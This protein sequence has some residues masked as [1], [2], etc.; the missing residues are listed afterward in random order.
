MKEPRLWIFIMLVVILGSILLSRF[1]KRELPPEENAARLELRSGEAMADLVAK[2]LKDARGAQ[3]IVL[4]APAVD[5]QQT[6]GETEQAFVGRAKKRDLTVL[7][8]LHLNAPERLAG[9]MQMPNL[10]A[11]ALQQALTGLGKVDAIVSL[12]GE[13]T[14]RRSDLESLPPF[15]CLCDQ[16]E[17]IPEL[18]KAGI[19]KAAYVPRRST[20]STPSAEGNAVNNWFA[21]LYE[22]ALPENVT[23]LYA[24]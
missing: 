20:P 8:T 24:E 6:T 12:C 23:A 2:Q 1:N 4:V 5:G 17:R 13:P 21:L 18:M 19:V 7:K 3:N 22:L 10:N 9:D 16:G 15:I 11:A 14:G